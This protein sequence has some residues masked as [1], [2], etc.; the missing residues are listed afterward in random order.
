MKKKA[1]N[2]KQIKEKF[3]S[4]QANDFIVLGVIFLS[5]IYIY[6]TLCKQ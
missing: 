4:R 3:M 2:V 1:K 5:K 6:L